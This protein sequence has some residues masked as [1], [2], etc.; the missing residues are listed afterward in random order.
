MNICAQCLQPTN[1]PRFCSCSCAAS[2]NNKRQPRRKL[3][4]SCRSCRTPIRSSRT[5]CAQCWSPKL[6]VSK[7]EALTGD[8]QRYRRIRSQAQCLARA[9]G[10]T[11]KCFVCGYTL[12]VE[13]CHKKPI[14]AYPLEARLSEINA[15]VNLVGLCPNHHWEFDHGLLDL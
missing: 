6:D 9:L 1:N 12:H 14:Q 11:T 13:T 2:F 3:E 7:G 8:T 10:L 5:Y 4:G 15:P